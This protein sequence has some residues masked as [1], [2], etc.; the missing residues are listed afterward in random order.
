MTVNELASALC[1]FTFDDSMIM[2]RLHSLSEKIGIETESLRTE[3]AVFKIFV[4]DWFAYGST[5][6]R[7][8]Y[9]SH[10]AEELMQAYLARL[11]KR[12][13][14]ENEE[15]FLGSVDR[16]LKAYNLAHDRSYA[17]CEAKLPRCEHGCRR[18]FLKIR[19]DRPDPRAT[20]CSRDVSVPKVAMV[21]GWGDA[22][23]IRA[24]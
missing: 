5:L 12:L 17:A 4:I 19:R 23:T 11:K 9:G 10:V 16:R 7:G 22:R 21:D 6:V 18:D 2:E 14:P 15:E 8:R 3:L 24:A 13:N 20:A 1:D